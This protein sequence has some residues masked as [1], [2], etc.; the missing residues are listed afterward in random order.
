VEGGPDLL[1]ALG[2]LP[3]CGVICMPSANTDFSPIARRQLA[4][5]RVLIIPHADEAGLKA[6]EG[7]G[8]QL[9]STRLE[10]LD[11]EGEAKDFNDWIKLTV[12]S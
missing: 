9:R 7:K 10:W 4:R 1:A 11:L 8:Q 3:K 5:R 2:H 12:Y 6:L